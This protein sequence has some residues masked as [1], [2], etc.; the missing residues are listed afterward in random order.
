MHRTLEKFT[1]NNHKWLHLA[2]GQ[3][4]VVLDLDLDRVLGFLE[5]F[6]RMNLGRVMVPKWH[7]IDLE[8]HIAASQGSLQ[9]RGAATHD[10]RDVYDLE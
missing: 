6:R 10:F 4:R 3:G 7:P 8:N 5:Q 1:Q 2:S 9:I